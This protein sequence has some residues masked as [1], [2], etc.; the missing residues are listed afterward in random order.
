MRNILP[1]STLADMRKGYIIRRGAYC[2]YYLCRRDGTHIRGLRPGVVRRA[3]AAGE[4]RYVAP[5][6][7]GRIADA[8]IIAKA[9]GR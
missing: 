4:I 6:I 8:W 2:G 1:L 9:E 5:G 7:K 3:V